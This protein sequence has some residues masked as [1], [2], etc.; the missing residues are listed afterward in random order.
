MRKLLE[1]RKYQ[2]YIKGSVMFEVFWCIFAGKVREGVDL[3][4]PFVKIW[5]VK[6]LPSKIDLMNC[7]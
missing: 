1:A 6:S 7:V 3:P 4:V 2:K 5:N